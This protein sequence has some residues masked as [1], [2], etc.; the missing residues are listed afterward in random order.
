MPQTI[1]DVATGV[2]IGGLALSACWGWLWLIIGTIGVARGAC[3]LRV[4]MHSLV[5][6]ISPLL[7][8]WGLWW[9]RAETFSPNTAFIVGLGLMPLV[10]IGFGL[11]KASDGRPAGLHMVEGMRYLTDQLLGAHEAC[12]GCGHDHGPD[13]GGRER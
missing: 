12:T 2:I 6:G 3:G 13:A 9:M 5:G 1:M 10:L 4:V 7:L 8:A 11:R